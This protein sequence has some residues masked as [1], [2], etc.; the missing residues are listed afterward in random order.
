VAL[1]AA[2]GANAWSGVK[3]MRSA[4]DILS[5]RIGRS[6]RL[7]FHAGEDRLDVLDLVRRRDLDAALQRLRKK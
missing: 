5:A 4:H 1:L 2:G 3:H 6:H 7:L